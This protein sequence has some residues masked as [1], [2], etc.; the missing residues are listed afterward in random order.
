MPFDGYL[1]DSYLNQKVGT[2]LKQGQ[3]FA[4]VQDSNQLFGEIRVPEY[5]AGEIKPGYQVEVKL[6]LYPNNP[7]SG[8]VVSIQPATTVDTDSTSSTS[9]I[10]QSNRVF[11]VKIDLTNSPETLKTGMS[12]YAKINVGKKPLFVLLTQ[13]LVRFIQ[14]EVWSWLP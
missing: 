11:K 5:D 13:P 14:I 7:F 6:L 12:G 4:I 8:K 9:D 2:Y 1:V 3:N 10:T